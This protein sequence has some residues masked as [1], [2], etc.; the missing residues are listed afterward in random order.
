VVPA[1]LLKVHYSAMKASGYPRILF[2]MGHTV[3]KQLPGT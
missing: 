3:R 1:H 2:P